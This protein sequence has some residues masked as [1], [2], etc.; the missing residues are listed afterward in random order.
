MTNAAKL[1]HNLFH[2]KTAP[3]KQ[4]LPNHII[5][6]YINTRVCQVK[7]VDSASCANYAIYYVSFPLTDGTLPILSMYLCAEEAEALQF[8][9]S[10]SAIIDRSNCILM[11]Q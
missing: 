10:A 4:M 7:P 2:G 6:E 1:V 5:S 8:F 11:V 9:N 3:L